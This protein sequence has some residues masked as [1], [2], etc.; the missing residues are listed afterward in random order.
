MTIEVNSEAGAWWLQVIVDW[1]LERSHWLTGQP[2][3]E[4][5][6]QEEQLPELH[7][8]PGCSIKVSGGFLPKRHGGRVIQVCE[9][10]SAVKPQVG[11]EVTDRK[12]SMKIRKE[13]VAK[14]SWKISDDE[15][16]CDRTLWNRIYSIWLLTNRLP[17]HSGRWVTWVY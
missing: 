16:D 11:V 9:G 6:Q 8:T 3:V 17:P 14:A 10:A 2:F 12:H 7:L 13:I 15:K 5:S 1:R 4:L